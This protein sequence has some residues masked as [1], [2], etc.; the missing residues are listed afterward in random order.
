MDVISRNKRICQLIAKQLWDGLSDH[1]KQELQEWIQA[2]P[3]NSTLYDELVRLERVRQYIEKRESIDVRKYM[4]VCER[5]LGLGGKRRVINRLWGYAA[6]IFVLCVVEVCIWINKQEKVGIGEIAQTVIEPGKVKA[7]LVLDDGREIEL[8]DRNASQGLEASGIVVV[9]DSSR[10]KYNQ[11]EGTEE[12]EVMNKIIVPTGGE[13]NLILSDG[14]WVYLNAESVITFPKKFVGE[15]REIIL[16]GEAY[17]HVTASKEHPFIV[18]TRDMDVLVTGT[19]F[20]VKAYP[21]ESNVQTTLLQGKVAVF[22][23]EDKKEKVEIQPNQQAEWD[24]GDVKLQ[25][26]EVDPD[27]FVAWKNGHFIFR[28]DRLEDIMRTLARWYDME[29]IYLD[30][31]I[32]DMAFAGKLDRSKDITPILNVLRATDKLTVEVNGKRIIL[33]VK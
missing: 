17:F 8:G 14:T 33:G 13:Y 5:E 23:G 31:S 20:N 6:A 29:V 21:D 7:L 3:D 27:L 10:I 30:T 22:A 32:K 2:S 9:S 26:R 15:R 16:E 19:E 28:Q 4:A 25:V 1:E 24:R 11:E 12:K 18:K